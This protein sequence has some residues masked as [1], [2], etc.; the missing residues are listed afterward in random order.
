MRNGIMNQ[1]ASS[2]WLSVLLFLG[3]LYIAPYMLGYAGWYGSETTR[4][5][6]FFVPFMQVLF[7][8]PVVYF[9]IKSLLNPEFK[10]SKKD[11][12]HFI[13][14]LMYLIYSLVVFIT[15]T[16]ILEEFYFYADGRDKD[17]KTWYQLLGLS[18]MAIYLILS[19]K[20]YLS[21][22]TV[23]FEVLS[24]ADSVLFR[25]IQNFLIS[26]LLLILIRVVFFFTNP[27]W[28]QF[29]SQFWYF[30]CFSGILF[31][32]GISGYTQAIKASSV[33]GTEIKEQPLNL[34]SEINNTKAVDPVQ[35]KPQ[36]I[37]LLESKQ[38]YKN[39]QLTLLDVAEQ[40]D[41]TS[42]TVS[43]VINSGFQMNFNDFINHYRVDEVKTKLKNGDHKH[44]TL[45]GIALDS[46]F[47]SK[48]TFNRAFKKSTGASPKDYIEKLS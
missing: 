15:D 14:G 33:I 36:L 27:Q 8:G 41:T 34:E 42:R 6:L 45:L 21:Y 17:L 32:I 35:W 29:G 9:Y 43:A 1:E 44:T 12:L 2:K 22:K 37:E 28:E 47:N 5:I 7:I 31:Y 19:L 20:H 23:I 26:F 18:S 16:I 10:F 11:L 25:W 46:G 13:P 3:A 4:H 48:A 39:P 38:L 30:I 24:Y 40:L